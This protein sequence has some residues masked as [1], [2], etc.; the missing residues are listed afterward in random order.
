VFAAAC[1]GASVFAVRLAVADYW[2]DRSVAMFPGNSRY[3]NRE[4]EQVEARDPQSPQ[5]DELLRRAVESNPRDT[6][7]L[8]RLGLRLEAVGNVAE[9]EKEL[10]RAAD[11]DHTFRPQWTLANFYF[12][13]DRL[14]DFWARARQCLELVERRGATETGALEA[15]SY[16]P[17][18]VF[19]LCW[20]ANAD[21]ALIREK[22]IPDRPVV[23]IAYLRY[24]LTTARL[25]AAVDLWSHNRA[26]YSKREAG[27]LGDFCDRLIAAGDGPRAMSVWDADGGLLF[28]A[29]LTRE[30]LNRGFDWVLE[31]T[32]IYRPDYLP[33]QHRLRIS[34]DRD[35]PDSMR[36]LSHA[37]AVESGARYSL[38]FVASGALAPGLR[39]H[40]G[41][42]PQSADVVS[43]PNTYDFTAPKDASIVRLVLE[44]QRPPG[45]AKPA[46]DVSLGDFALDKLP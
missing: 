25:D 16:D 13:Q 8:M 45:A 40:V 37:V 12:R 29:A 18:P 31:G 21:A 44:Y 41:M 20:Q 1:I 15:G 32:G 4:A 24:L 10:L 27:L 14:T 6:F 23:H 7:A 42:E 34:S 3:L 46:G 35:M 26:S 38:R 2:P 22:A 11:L 30:P 33:E 43:G 28:N 9:A 17:K 5:V 36:F 19:D 39:W